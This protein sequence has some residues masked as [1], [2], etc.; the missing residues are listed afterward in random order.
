MELEPSQSRD[1]SKRT[2]SY[3]QNSFAS[4]RFISNQAKL[5]NTYISFPPITS[6]NEYLL[7]PETASRTQR[8]GLASFLDIFTVRIDPALWPEVHWSFKVSSIVGHRPSTCVYFSLPGASVS[9]IR[10]HTWHWMNENIHHSGPSDRQRKCLEK[11][12]GGL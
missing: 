1:P 3:F 9:D 11:F 12:S 6:D 10:L 7:A 2:M 5:K 8:E 4:N